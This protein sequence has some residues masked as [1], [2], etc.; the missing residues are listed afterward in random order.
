M[1]AHHTDDDGEF[2][3]LLRVAER[4][5]AAQT[6]VAVRLA[7][8]ERLTEPERRSLALRCQ[9]VAA[10]EAG[11]P[12]TIILKRAAMEGYDPDEP[13]GPAARL[14]NDWAGAAFLSALP[15]GGTLAPR[16]YGG[17]RAAG[18]VALEDLGQ[19]ATL[20]D[21]LLA[22]DGAAAERALL[23]LA[24]TLGRL[25]ASTI[26]RHDD[27]RALRAS[28]GPVSADT[29]QHAPGRVR[30]HLPE[31]ASALARLE[32]ALDAAALAEVEA[33][34]AAL[35]APGPFWAYT[36]GDPCPDND[37]ILR[38]G[39]VR[40]IDFEFGGYRHALIDGMYGW[41]QFPTCW[42]AGGIPDGALA[43]MEAAYRAELARGCPA[44]DND[45]LWQRSVAQAAAYWM[46]TAL[47]WLLSEM[48]DSDRE[49][50]IAWVRPRVI[51]RLG[52]FA[53][54]AR[55]RGQLPALA[56]FAGRLGAELERRWPAERHALALY[57][58][59]TP[60]P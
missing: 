28:L 33:T 48:L 60:A 22:R 20:V 40:L 7:R 56:A 36:H 23:A 19:S 46:L 50:G 49:W 39:S 47:W 24:V 35:E 11:L 26:G 53:R 34:L 57:P 1:A 31:I 30:A 9:V 10:P 27:Y 16:C 3:E 38:D 41:M 13:D 14:F 55:A 21:P 6:G 52:A 54:I 45:A 25:H 44:A 4:V 42:C 51:A 12:A 15:N 8:P 58:A 32:L 59:F 37:F 18:L 43:R 5:V 29:I 17:D 2:Q